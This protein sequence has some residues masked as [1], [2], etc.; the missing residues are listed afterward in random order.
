MKTSPEMEKD[1]TRPKTSHEL[2][3]GTNGSHHEHKQSVVN[4]LSRIEGHI[5]AIKRMVEEDVPC[6]DVLIQIAA[7]RSALNGAGRVILEDHLKNCLVDAIANG[8]FDNVY[9]DLKN[10]LDRFID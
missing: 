7:V 1:M 5:R 2:D 10:S 3:P 9:N 8:D 4:R 6:P